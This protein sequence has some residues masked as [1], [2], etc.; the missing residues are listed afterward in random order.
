MQ[1]QDDLQKFTAT[2]ETRKIMVVKQSFK[3]TKFLRRPM[4]DQSKGT[5]GL[6]VPIQ[7]FITGVQ[8]DHGRL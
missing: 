6:F 2:S 5:A 4:A 1:P 7:T 3:I 8:N